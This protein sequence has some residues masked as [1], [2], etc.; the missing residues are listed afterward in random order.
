MTNEEN[1]VSQIFR[2][3]GINRVLVK[4]FINSIGSEL[5]DTS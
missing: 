1:K 3:L 2:T 5:A 4:F